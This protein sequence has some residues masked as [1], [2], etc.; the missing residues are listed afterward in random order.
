VE[1]IERR[2]AWPGLLELG[3][4]DRRREPVGIYRKRV[5]SRR[6]KIRDARRFLNNARIIV[7][8]ARSRPDTRRFP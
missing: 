1:R 3:L 6:G 8:S 5:I 7:M 4:K 2:E